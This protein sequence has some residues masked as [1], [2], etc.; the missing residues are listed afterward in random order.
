MKK[1]L[2]LAKVL[3]ICGISFGQ[4]SNYLGQSTVTV[5]HMVPY[6]GPSKMDSIVKIKPNFKGKELMEDT[7][8]PS[9]NPDWV[10]QQHENTEKVATASLLWQVAGLT[11]GVSPYDPSGDVDNNVYLQSINGSG[12]AIYK[13]YNKLTGAAVSGTLT[14][15]ALGGVGGLGDPII[16]YHKSAQRWIL[17]EFSASGNKLLVHVS[18]TSSP[19]GAYYTHTFTCP[20]FPDY[21]KY[22]IW[23]NQDIMTVT[24][25][26]GGPPT[27]Y[28]MRL[29]NLLAGT[30]SPF[31]G[32]DITYSL[33]GFGFQSI[34]PVDL[35]GDT[36]ASA[37]TKPLF[38]RHRDDES[39]TNGSPDSPTNDWIELWEMTVNW[40]NSTATVAKIQDIAVTEFDSKLCGLTSFTCIGQPGT[41][42]K[43]DPLREPLMYKV[44]MR[45]FS[46]HETILMAFATD[47]NGSDRSGVRW[48]EI[49]RAA[50]STGAWSLYQ[51]GT[52]APGTTTSRWMP[53]I[54][55]DGD[56]NILLAYSSSST[57]AGDWP[58]IKFTGRKPC[59]P[60]GTMT[61]AETT[62]KAGTSAKTG[63]DTRWGDYHHMSVDSYLDNVFYY[64]GLYE[65][66]GDKSNISA[67]KINPDATDASIFEVFQVIPGTV[68][69]SST[70][71]GVVVKNKGTNAITSG[72]IQWQVGAGPTTNVNYTSSQLTATNT[73]D[74]VYVTVSGMA[75]G[76]NTVNFNSITANGLTPDDN[77]C[78][79]QRAITI[80][81]GAGS[82]LTTSAAVTVQ[83]SCTPGNDGQ[84]TLTVSGGSA[85][86][87]YAINGGSSQASNIFNGVAQGT[88][89][90]IITDNTGCSGSGNVV[91][92]NSVVITV[93]PSVSSPILCNGDANGAVSVSATGG[94]GTY[95][96]SSD[97]S[98][99]QAGNTFGSLNASTYTLYAKDANGCV[100]SN[101][102]IV[103]QPAVLTL[104]AIPIPVSCFGGN[105]GGVTASATNGTPSYTYSLD[106][107]TYSA[108]ATFSGLAPGAVTVYVMDN[109]GCL[110]T[111]NT[112]VTQPS[113]V[114]VSGVSTVANANDGTI[115]LTGNGGNMPYTYSINGT[116]YQSGSLFTGLAGG[117]YTCYVQ[118]NNGCINTVSVHVNALGVDELEASSLQLVN[119]YPNPTTGS[120]NLEVSGVVNNMIEVKIFNMNGQLISLI[121]VPANNGTVNQTIELSKK[122]AVGQYYIGIYDGTNTP[123]I[124]KIV[125]Q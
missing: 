75:A 51:E 121:E 74:T 4:T 60:L 98:T 124:S 86:Y 29:S 5:S 90:Y 18:Q 120:F 62:I 101:T 15:D 35:E 95:T 12:G 24:T 88:T 6:S 52:Y 100:G 33:N 58:S 16:L 91:V 22:S 19:T 2:I 66:A 50:G 83:P 119:L 68:C 96:Y 104:N 38:M 77:T 122:I 56:G 105:D 40:T 93:T 106:G 113:Q 1:S 108:T 125:K 79:D 82:G 117:T 76:A 53:G 48:V 118:D 30:T 28:A 49:R 61:I 123:I 17:T 14:M 42:N 67:I 80:T 81:T 78:N 21:P 27:V 26:E 63:G 114:T 36:P 69:G 20:S 103:T 59:D 110:D 73:L 89:T 116:T 8:L 97:G 31:I 107:V 71:V 37:T 92:S 94:T 109:N 111:Y 46:D 23:E 44:P 43:L 47:V 64:T 112:T 84:V 32:V 34:T 25:N 39:H 87:S 11:A 85:P 65:S 41:T 102:I 72:T 13:T 10:W 115:T 54:N 70:Q 9:H 45:I 57:T 7:S 55:M 99:Y 3:F